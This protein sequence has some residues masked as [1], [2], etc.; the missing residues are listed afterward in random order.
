MAAGDET[1]L[2]PQDTTTAGV[3]AMGALMDTA[4]VGANDQYITVMG[5]NS[6]Q[7]WVIHIEGA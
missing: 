3:T 1:I 6:M 4:Y 7:F 5:A 2:G